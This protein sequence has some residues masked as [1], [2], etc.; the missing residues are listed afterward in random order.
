MAAMYRHL[1][2]LLASFSALVPMH[3][4]TPAPV[5]LPSG[6]QVLKN[7]AEAYKSPQRYLFAGK[8]VIQG[9]SDPNTQPISFTLAIEMPDKIRLEGDTKAFGVTAFAGPVLFVSDGDT[10][11]LTEPA[12]KKYYQAKRTSAKQTVGKFENRYP[13][14]DKPEQFAA[15]LDHFVTGRYPALVENAHL[16]KVTKTEKLLIAGR[17]VECYVV[18]IDRGAFEEKRLMSNS[19]T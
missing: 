14:L 18:Q 9:P 1:I 2:A 5:P 4:Q 7:V 19:N 8:G 10:A 17:F 6:E 16:A 15:Y 11:S 12:T 3:A 13:A